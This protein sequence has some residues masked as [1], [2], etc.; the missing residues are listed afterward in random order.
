MLAARLP[1]LA[2]EVFADGVQ[3][4]VEPVGVLL[5]NASNLIDDCV[6]ATHTVSNCRLLSLST[7]TRLLNPN[8][9]IPTTLSFAS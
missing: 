1:L 3:V 4:T 6:V 5:S 9:S 2:P 8:I 7:G